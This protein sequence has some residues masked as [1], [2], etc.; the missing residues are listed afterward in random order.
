MATR[1]GV[2]GRARLAAL[3]GVALACTAGRGGAAEPDWLAL[4]DGMVQKV[5]QLPD[6]DED[7]YG[8]LAW[9][10]S[11]GMMA[12]NVLYEATRD[13][14]YLDTQAR[15][16]EQL[17]AKRDSELAARG[18]GAYV[19]FQRG[20]VVNAWGTGH[21]TD[22][23]HTCWLVHAGMLLYPA[24]EFVRLVRRGGEAAA[25]YAARA[26][27]LLP[28]IEDAIAEFDADWRE[29]PAEGMG[30]YVLPDGK[31]LPNN[32][33]NA[34]GCALFV[35]ADLTGNPGYAHK[36][37]AMAAFFRS[38]LTHVDDGDYYLWAYSQGTPEGPPGTGE[39]VSHAAINARFAYI[40]WQHG[41]SFT[42][43]DMARLART[44][45]MGLYLGDGRFAGAL[46]E[47]TEGNPT[48]TAQIVRWGF[49]AR[50]EPETEGMI[51]AYL[52]ANP[53][54]LE[55]GGSTTALGCAYLARARL[56]YAA[57]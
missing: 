34:A 11:Y 39:D 3:V 47:R 38:K 51:A 53:T 6:H 33:M 15:T 28:A 20:R 37:A 9:G 23:K 50:F 12:L 5:D 44:V 36:A 13:A 19:D 45:S 30:Y 1:G 57:R 24:A 40:A 41:A 25:P 16:L 14:K 27:A 56:L 21:Y 48:Y 52:E 8:E 54:V 4:A 18:D 10:T 43:E 29:G 49:L 26:E 42:D 31:L 35:L 7:G 2:A 46:G 17:M 32:Q 55:A 22:G